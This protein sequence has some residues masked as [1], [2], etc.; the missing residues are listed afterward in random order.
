MIE[1]KKGMCTCGQ[2]PVTK[3]GLMCDDCAKAYEGIKGDNEQKHPEKFMEDYEFVDML[4]E[5][6]DE[7][8][9]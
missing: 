5:R 3:Y 2:G 6:Y 1:L 7:I 4:R 8:L 9:P